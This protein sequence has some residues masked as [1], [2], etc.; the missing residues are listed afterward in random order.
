MSGLAVECGQPV[1]AM[2]RII[3][4]LLVALAT[5]FVA[6][7]RLS[8]GG[9]NFTEPPPPALWENA[10]PPGRPS[11]S[12][13]VTRAAHG[14]TVTYPSPW[15][16]C[17]TIISTDPNSQYALT[18]VENGV[19]FDIDDD[20][21]LDQVAWTAPATDVAFLARDRDGDGRITSGRELIGDR[22][23][24]GVAN[25]PNALMR[26]AVHPDTWP[27]LDSDNPL[28]GELRLWRDANHN[29]KSEPSELRRAADELS[30]IGLGYERHRWTDSYGNQSRF[31]GFVHVRTAPRKN[32]ATTPEDDQARRRY[33]YEVCLVTQ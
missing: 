32:M 29:G 14:L 26:L 2:R 27:Q 18:A 13:V 1:T 10:Q 19:L 5:L 25:G 4:C 33:M 31:R 28:F 23:V 20:G 17:A 12:P 16:N 6:E 7:I 24:P 11:P 3:V 21:D 30:T 9:H 22:T 15:M 8:H